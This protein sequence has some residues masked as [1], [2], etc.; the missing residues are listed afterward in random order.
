MPNNNLTANESAKWPQTGD[1]VLFVGKEAPEGTWRN[2]LENTAEIVNI[3]ILDGQRVATFK[4]KKLPFLTLLLDGL[5]EDGDIVKPKTEEQILQEE[6][7]GICH[8]HC[9]TSFQASEICGKLLKSY[10][11]TRKE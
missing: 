8:K 10:N 3:F 4:N 2:Y 7:Y 9:D 11:I 6:I 5:L 1:T